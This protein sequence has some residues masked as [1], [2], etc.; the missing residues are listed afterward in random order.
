MNADRAINMEQKPAAS[1]LW[2]ELL[3]N[4]LAQNSDL[5]SEDALS[6]ILEFYEI[7]LKENEVQNL[8][9]LTSPEDFYQ[10]HVRDVLE[11]LKINRIQFP[12]LDLGSG[13]GIPGLLA[14]LI[15]PGAWILAESEKRKAEYLEKAVNI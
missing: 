13:V 5:L 9:R 4:L 11:L 3:K 14:A 12:A 8:T 7:V 1:D 2:P 15:Q 10:S 6:R